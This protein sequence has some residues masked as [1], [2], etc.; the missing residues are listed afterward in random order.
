MRL[1]TERETTTTRTI[2]DLRIVAN[3]LAVRLG[4][5]MFSVLFTLAIASLETYKF[6]CQRL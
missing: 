3:G 6:F 1:P 5:G 4:V 2:T